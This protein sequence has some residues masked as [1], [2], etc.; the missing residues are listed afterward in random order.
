MSVCVRGGGGGRERERER[1]RTG[2]K[3]ESGVKYISKHIYRGYTH[4]YIHKL[5][6]YSSIR[7]LDRSSSCS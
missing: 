6:N 7:E 5:R 2:E 3:R 1:E 4:N